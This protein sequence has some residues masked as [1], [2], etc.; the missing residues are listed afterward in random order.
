[1]NAA[2]RLLA[3]GLAAALAGGALADPGPPAGH[4]DIER[5]LELEAGQV[6]A[7]MLPGWRRDARVVVRVDSPARLAALQAAAGSLE[8][9][10]ATTDAE[11]LAALEGATAL[12]GFCAARLLDAGRRL[13]WVQL[14][15][16]G[17]E[18]CV[19]L[20]A[21]RD[22]R[23]LLTNMQ[24]VSAP[25]IA[26]HVM[27]LLLG[28]TRGL[29]L[30]RTAQDAARWDPNRVPM[31]T[32]WELGGRTLLLVGLG[33]I[34]TEIARRADA[35]G[36]RIV[37]VRASGRPGPDFVDAV[38]RPDRLL[39]LAAEADAIVNS[40][41]L[42]PATEGLFDARFFAA[43]K[44]TAFFINVGRGASVKTDDLLA[45]LRAGELAGAGLD[46]T[47]PE[48]LPADHP[49]WREP[50]VVITPH[51]SAGSDRISDRLFEV[52]AANLARYA[53]GEPLLSV[54]E[55]ARGY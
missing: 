44:P 49:L 52:V 45:A 55:P 15:S 28:F 32:R 37:A 6:A 25:Q 4:A 3:L 2:H 12:V 10:P 43:M 33:G 18:N 30:Y 14:Y 26:E 40:A 46:V 27:A 42:T 11:A 24:H 54:V 22:G 19:D 31:N 53:R 20:P 8:L 48:P 9:V 39:E 36:L 38:A 47:D 13:N 50:R 1:M 16:A 21:V 34:G 17:A 7:R 23:V 35:F 29:D 5:R 41:P 51:V